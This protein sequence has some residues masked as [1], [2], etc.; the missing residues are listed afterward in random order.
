MCHV[1]LVL[2]DDEDSGYTSK[3]R[4]ESLPTAGSVPDI[5]ELSPVCI[6]HFIFVQLTNSFNGM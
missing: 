2:V 1:I 5:S 4:T 3:N 6:E